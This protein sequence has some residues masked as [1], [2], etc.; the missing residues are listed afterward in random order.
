MLL[1]L[2]FGVVV[3]VASVWLFSVCFLG[4]LLLLLFFVIAL[5][6]TV[7]YCLAFA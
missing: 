3:A 7:R 6:V 2:L 5:V 4:V 1:L